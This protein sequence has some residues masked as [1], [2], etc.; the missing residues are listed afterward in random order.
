MHL[1]LLDYRDVFRSATTLYT[2]KT[3]DDKVMYTFPLNFFIANKVIGE[4]NLP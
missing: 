4:K 2:G 1:T 3:M